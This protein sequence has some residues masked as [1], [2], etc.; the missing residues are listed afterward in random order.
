MLKRTGFTLIELLV[1]I[2]IIAILAAIL[3]P[4]FARAREKARQASCQSNL[5]QIGT[6]AV[7][8]ATDYDGT[9]PPYYVNTQ[10][11][12]WVD[13]CMPYVKNAQLFICP[14][15]SGWYAAAGGCGP[16]THPP[17]GSFRYRSDPGNV[18]YAWNAFTEW[19]GPVGA[20][21]STPG[22]CYHNQCM[23][24]K[25]Q[26]P[27]EKIM[28]TDGVCPRT[29]GIP[30]VTNFHAGNPAYAIHNGGNNFVFVDGHVKFRNKVQYWEFDTLTS[31]KYAGP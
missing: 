28:A 31:N 12:L 23:D 20:T 19:Y 16:T 13:K 5:K 4:V 18:S 29:W 3:F 25:I 9:Y 27:A 17:E 6:A 14:S 15:M 10:A 24:S 30:W 1:V 2:A 22:L 11:A 8:Y 26:M 21:S 7:M